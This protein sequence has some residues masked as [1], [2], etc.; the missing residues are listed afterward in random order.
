V[1]VTKIVIPAAGLG[2]RFLP[3]TKAIPKEMLPVI[4]KPLVQ[5]SIEEG[6]ASE[7]N[8][9]ILVTDK[10]KNA[11]ANHID[12]DH[13][14][15]I[16]LAERNIKNL[17]DST[18]RIGRLGNYTY[19]RQREPLGLGH[20]VWLAQ[21]CINPKEYFGI[22]LP[23]EM[24]DSKEPA[25][26]QLLRIAYQ[27]KASVI[28]VQEI[29]QQLVSLHDIIA[30]K[31]TITPSLFQVSHIVEKP[32]VKDAPSR[33]AI[34]G[35]YVVSSKIFNSIDYVSSSTEGTEIQL[36]KSI[37]ALMQSNE[38]VF[39]YKVQ[40]THY[41]IDT[42]LAWLKANIGYALK[43]PEYAPHIRNMIKEDSLPDIPLFNPAKIV[44][45]S[46]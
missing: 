16:T 32:N 31:K 46:L 26:K 38:R 28:A 23:D 12:A 18:E 10:D 9:F 35:R 36:N 4:N 34:V 14:H 7:I 41:T 13:P 2:T 29:P 19:I 40:G 44:E 11:I 20:A 25:L 37:S 6:L 45:K 3:Y 30:V 39:A 43:N 21:Q 33:L 1:K 42:P 27:E 8:N 15:A 24:I 22:M 17:L 5:Y